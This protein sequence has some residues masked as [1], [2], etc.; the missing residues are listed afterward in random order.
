[1]DA[2]LN[3]LTAL[4]NEQHAVLVA[5]ARAASTFGD[6][7]VNHSATTSRD[8]TQETEESA[9]P[10]QTGV[11]GAPVNAETTQDAL[12]IASQLTGR[13]QVVVPII[14]LV[15]LKLLVDNFIAG[16]AVIMSLSSFYRLKQGFD[17]ELAM[18]GKSNRLSLLTL[19]L[20]STALLCCIL[21]E[22]HR[23]GYTDSVLNR[24]I[25]RSLPMDKSYSLLE[26]LWSCGITDMIVQL[27]VLTAKLAAVSGLELYA[28]A[29]VSD[30]SDSLALD[31]E[32]GMSRGG[33][34]LRGLTAGLTLSSIGTSITG[35]VRRTVAPSSAAS[36]SHGH[37]YSSVANADAGLP[38]ASAVSGAAVN[39]SDGSA[40][41]RE[42]RL[43]LVKT[44][45]CSLLDVLGLVYRSALPVTWWVAY[46]R[47]P[48]AA[49]VAV[50]LQVLYVA[51][52][53]Q[54]ISTKCSGA[55]VALSLFIGNKIVSL[56]HRVWLPV[57]I[58]N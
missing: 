16:A 40:T 6:A 36:S 28:Q 27:M 4:L 57:L 1:M 56:C 10:T 29:L 2:T 18:K 33:G 37:A 5:N 39:S 44:R 32:G 8:S 21:F 7:N 58:V 52:K 43:Y 34:A 17:F 41:D 30:A 46:L 49:V 50:V 35:L 14:A 54:D 20:F 38:V 45:V 9:S 15:L 25:F 23:F 31:L 47:S 19:L 22:I 42:N 11:P 48:E 12:R 13:L 3:R 24:L 55:A 51:V 26:T 53:L